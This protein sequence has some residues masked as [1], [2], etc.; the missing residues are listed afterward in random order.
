MKK[1]QIKM[2]RHRRA[3]RII[4]VFLLAGL[5]LG[6]LS[7]FVTGSASSRYA[8]E[9]TLPGVKPDDG[10]LG[11]A[12]TEFLPLTAENAKDL[13]DDLPF[14]EVSL[15]RASPLFYPNSGTFAMS[16]Q[17]ALECL[18]SAIYYEAGSE[19]L[20]GKR[21]VAQ[22]ILNRVAHP[23]FPNRVCGVVYQGSER[24]TGCQFSFTCDGS[25]D[26]RPSTGGW[27]SA[28]RIATHA[29]NGFVEPSV[30]LATH[31]HADYV[32]PYWAQSLD[33][34]AVIGAH[35]FYNWRGSWGRRGAFSQAL[36]AEPEVNF[37]VGDQP[38]E[39]QAAAPLN[40]PTLP[41]LRENSLLRL[42]PN[43]SESLNLPVRQIE[44][45]RQSGEL[46]VD[47]TGGRLKLDDQPATGLSSSLQN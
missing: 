29:F 37:R 41:E 46:V 30:G 39:E 11:A 14:A 2:I 21:A 10:M 35:I 12:P 27:Q 40:S 6:A 31:Y 7:S 9:F 36:E 43:L 26:R 16:R 33:K 44:A 42:Q 25:L 18:A 4:G 1:K 34:I 19:S 22:V 13:N 8:I 15:E 45:D 17:S 3:H 5:S 20:E 28:Y 47:E 32:V 23:A 38:D 24:R